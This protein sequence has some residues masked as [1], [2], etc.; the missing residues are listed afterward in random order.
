VAT[1]KRSTS[2]LLRLG[3]WIAA[4]G[5]FAMAVLPMHHGN[6]F[7]P[8]DKAQHFVAFYALTVLALLAFPRVHVLM[9]AVALSAFGAL[10][11]VVQGL[12]IVHRD[13]DW[14]DWLADTLAIAAV[15][16]PMQL[17]RLRRG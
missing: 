13:C 4:I 2:L 16:V 7:L 12:P 3:F 10:I 5:V 6:S 17:V 1:L 14:H 9:P 15:L 8:W 11:E